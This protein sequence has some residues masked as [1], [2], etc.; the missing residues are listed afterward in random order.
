MRKDGPPPEKPS[1]KRVSAAAVMS[2]SAF[3]TKTTSKSE[4]LHHLQ[5]DYHS[6]DGAEV[7]TDGR[8]S[9]L[10]AAAPPSLPPQRT[11]HG[12]LL[13]PNMDNDAIDSGRSAPTSPAARPTS[14]SSSPYHEPVAAYAKDQTSAVVATAERGIVKRKRS[15]PIAEEEDDGDQADAENG[16]LGIVGVRGAIGWVNM[17]GRRKGS[18]GVPSSG[19]GSKRSGM[20]VLQDMEEGP[21]GRRH[22]MLI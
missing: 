2:R 14:S 8:F 15:R 7:D 13:Q 6:D 18:G 11:Q 3:T 20:M 17:E 10:E 1:K 16:G 9:S 4:K 21:G 12:Q 5:S 19:S 22:T